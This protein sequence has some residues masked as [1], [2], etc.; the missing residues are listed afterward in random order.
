MLPSSTIQGVDD[1]K[2]QQCFSP[3]NRT[4][5]FAGFNLKPD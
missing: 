2:Y 4:Q 3:K 1:N 5:Q